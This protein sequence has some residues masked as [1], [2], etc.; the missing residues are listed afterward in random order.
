MDRRRRLVA[1]IAVVTIA[2]GL[3]TGFVSA[4]GRD[5]MIS[6]FAYS[7]D[8]VT[9]NVGDSVTWTNDDA[10]AHTATGNGWNTGDLGNGESASITFQ[11][12]GTFE[13]MCGIHPAMRGTVVVRAAGG[14]TPPTDTDAVP[15][16]DGHD[17]LTTTLAFLGIVMLVGTVVAERRFRERRPG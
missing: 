11:A 17:W 8:P 12:A 3:A 2:L 6:G 16:T 9:V 13:Y 1:A 7:P 10:Q 5:V 14:T 15:A 4:A